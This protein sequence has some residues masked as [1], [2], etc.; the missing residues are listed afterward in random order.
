MT[1]EITFG[2]PFESSMNVGD[3]MNVNLDYERFREYYPEVKSPKVDGFSFESRTY[4]WIPNAIRA[5]EKEIGPLAIAKTGYS[6]FRAFW[7]PQ[8]SWEDISDEMKAKDRDKMY[9]AIRHVVNEYE[10]SYGH[11]HF[12]TKPRDL[13]ISLMDCVL[14]KLKAP[15]NGYNLERLRSFQQDAA[16]EIESI[17][18]NV[19]EGL[20]DSAKARA[21]EFLVSFFG[22]DCLSESEMFRPELIKRPYYLKNSMYYYGADSKKHRLDWTTTHIVVL[23]GW[24]EIARIAGGLGRRVVTQ[25]DADCLPTFKIGQPPTAIQNSHHDP[26]KLGPTPLRDPGRNSRLSPPI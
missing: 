13:E 9:K 21:K 4:I 22:F 15:H 19:E 1:R 24:F 17:Y 26:R 2:K 10:T 14:K 16:D 20:E 6:H 11:P 7:T 25:A 23:F 5:I 8:G 12:I 3:Q 18:A